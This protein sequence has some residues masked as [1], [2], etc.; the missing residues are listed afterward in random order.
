M[1]GKSNLILLGSDLKDKRLIDLVSNDRGQDVEIE[2]ASCHFANAN[3]EGAIMASDSEDLLFDTTLVQSDNGDEEMPMQDINIAEDYEMRHEAESS[4]QDPLQSR[5]H[6]SEVLDAP[7]K[8]SL[9]VEDIGHPESGRRSMSGSNN[10]PSKK[11]RLLLQEFSQL[12]TMYEEE[13]EYAAEVGLCLE[14]E[15]QYTGSLLSALEREK[16]YSASLC[17]EISLEKSHNS[18]LRKALKD[19]KDLVSRANRLIRDLESSV[20]DLELKNSVLRER[21]QKS[22]DLDSN[23]SSI[24]SRLK[25]G[26]DHGEVSLKSLSDAYSCFSQALALVSRSPSSSSSSSL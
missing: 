10:R 3:K 21:L 11:A 1:Q 12:Q 9:S 17:K 18:Q 13:K 26:L 14:D 4:S 7:L 15:R 19:E 6:M 25:Q 23:R 5:S 24:Q 16:E 20:G 8:R 2:I 22:K